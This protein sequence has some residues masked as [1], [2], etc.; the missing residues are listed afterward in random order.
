[1]VSKWHPCQ[2]L[3]SSTGLFI[4]KVLFPE[5]QCARR[6]FARPP[7]RFD[8]VF[9]DRRVG[10]DRRIIPSVKPS[11]NPKNFDALRDPREQFLLLLFMMATEAQKE[12]V[13]RIFK[14]ATPVPF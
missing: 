13:R 11:G 12:G 8:L 14:I 5:H 2:S 9:W 3:S 4:S 1:M 6:A 7:F 10:E